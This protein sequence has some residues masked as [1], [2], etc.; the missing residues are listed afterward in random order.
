MISQNWLRVIW[1]LL[2]YSP[3]PTQA[4]AIYAILNGVRFLLICGGARAGKSFTTVAI[5]LM[6]MEPTVEELESGGVGSGRAPRHCWIV[7]PDYRQARA[8]FEYL[9]QALQRGGFVA[10]VSMPLNPTSSWVMT[11]TW[12]FKVETKSSSDIRKLA[13]YS[14][15]IFLMVEAAQQEYEVFLRGQERVAQGRGHVILSGTLEEGLPWYG[16]MLKRW[17]GP[18]DEGGFALSLPTWSN[19]HA[20]PGGWDDPE[21]QRIYRQHV[22]SSTLDHFEERYGAK[23]RKSTGLV[24]VEFD[25]ARNV[26]RMQP[27][28]DVPIELW[29]DPGKNCYCVLFVQVIGLVTNVLDRVYLRGGIAQ[30]AIEACQANPLFDLVYKNRGTHGVIDVAGRHQYGMPSHIEIWQKT[31]GLSFRSNYVH[32]DVGRDVVRFRLRDDPK[33]GHPLLFFNSHMTNAKSPDGQAADVLAEFEL[34]KWR[35]TGANRSEPRR[36]IDS[37]NHA[38]KALGYG[39]YDHFGPTEERKVIKRHRKRSAWATY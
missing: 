1:G 6:L 11:T 13:S 32:Q 4:E 31:A 7:G 2:G 29:V 19:T 33:L 30:D 38:I 35:K 17:E 23:P 22:N 21:I 3:N 25:Y 5:A 34:W 16:D 20:F 9:W 24:I 12:G 27:D 37:N 10:T 18:N 39:L 36:P 26:R 28:Y 15:D 8:E 14:V